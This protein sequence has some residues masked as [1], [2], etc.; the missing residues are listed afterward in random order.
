MSE[1]YIFKHKLDA[2]N[3]KKS[4]FFVKDSE[5]GEE[6][7]IVETVK[8]FVNK[9][10]R[11]EKT[12]CSE[13][14]LEIECNLDELP[15]SVKNLEHHIKWELECESV[16]S[17][18]NTENNLYIFPKVFVDISSKLKIPKADFFHKEEKL[19]FLD[20]QEFENL[21]NFFRPVEIDLNFSKGYWYNEKYYFT[22]KVERVVFH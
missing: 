14:E 5:T 9:I 15:Q 10:E 11:K 2:K 18:L 19:K 13:F 17:F 7:E 20:S 22:P 6:K 16:C 3:R 21:I 1:E 12:F 8:C 4:F